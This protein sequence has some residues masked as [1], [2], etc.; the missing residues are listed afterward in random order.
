V[1]IDNRYPSSPIAESA[2]PLTVLQQIQRTAIYIQMRTQ[3]N[4]HACASE[5]AELERAA[6]VV[7]QRCRTKTTARGN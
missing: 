4:L 2:E 3:V 5:L 7:V 6:G 1:A